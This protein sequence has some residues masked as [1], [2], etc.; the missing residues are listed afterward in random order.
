MTLDY[1]KLRDLLAADP[2]LSELPD[3]DAADALNARVVGG[4]RGFYVNA[5]TIAA[6]AGIAKMEAV[7]GYLKTAAPTMHAIMA[8]AGPNDG[9]AGGVDVNHPATRQFIGQLVAGGLLAQADADALN[10]L[11]AVS[12]PWVEREFGVP[13]LSNHDIAHAR[14]L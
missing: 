11:A 7:M 5:R 9:S 14:S 4:S 1:P 12:L 2:A 3:A 13:S 10:G 8:Q 6:A